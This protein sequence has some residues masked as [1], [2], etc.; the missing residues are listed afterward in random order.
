MVQQKQSQE[1]DHPK[2][3][4]IFY[5]KPMNNFQQEKQKMNNVVCKCNC[6]LHHQ[7]NQ[8]LKPERVQ[9]QNLNTKCS[10]E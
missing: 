5:L 2:I 8:V 4:D 6:H 7:E 10:P 3:P 1:K 9:W